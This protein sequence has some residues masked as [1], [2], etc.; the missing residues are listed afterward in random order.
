MNTQTQAR[1]VDTL[2]VVRRNLL[3][4][5]FALMA[6]GLG[7][8]AWPRLL[9]AVPDRPLMDGVVDAVLCAMQLLAI[10]GIFAPA[11]MLPILVF[12]VLW[13]AIWALSVALPLAINGEVSGEVAE[14]LFA[15][16]IAVPF[17][18]IIPWRT[19]VAELTAERESWRR[20]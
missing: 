19:I 7:F 20:R 5:C 3:R 9:T 15:C 10:V 13:K 6:V 18:F 11:R 14:T 4:A 1:R 2:S 17:V 16:A 12:E 8:T